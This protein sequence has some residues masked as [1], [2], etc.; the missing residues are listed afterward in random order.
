MTHFNKVLTILFILLQTTI[1]AQME[2]KLIYVGDPMCSWCYGIAEELEKTITHF[3]GKLETELVL[4]GLRP[5]NTET[6]SDLKSFLTHHWE[7]VHAKS[8]QKFNYS[9]LDDTKMTYD[10]EPPSR[11][12]LAVRKMDA[13]KEIAFFKMVQK[14]FYVDNIN[15]HLDESYFPLVEKLGLD[16]E[17]F[18][19][20][21]NASELKE[22]IKLDFKRA[23]DLGVN[24]F[25]TIVLQKDNK[26]NIIARGFATCETMIANIERILD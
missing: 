26:L 10:T 20:L 25:P 5:Y 17:K 14:A 24:S 9:I 21:F 12:V 8:G 16:A 6:M 19:A 18:A 22:E 1:F 15:V 11:A 7:E 13:S 4:G 23:G 2:T 3:E